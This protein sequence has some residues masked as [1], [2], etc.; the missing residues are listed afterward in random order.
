MDDRYKRFTPHED[1]VDEI[2][3][4]DHVNELQTQIQSNQRELYR[5]DD[6]DFLDRALFIL[7]HHTV[8]N[9]LYIDLIDDITKVDLPASPGIIFNEE[10][11]SFTLEDTDLREALLITKP[12][13]NLNNTN[14]RDVIFMASSNL[15]VGSQITYEISNNGVNFYKIEPNEANV[16]EIPTVG[17]Q[18]YLR[19][20]FYRSPNGETP[21]LKG[22]AIL[23]R[24]AKYVVN[25]AILDE[26]KGECKDCGENLFEGYSHKDLID[27][28]PD[29]HHPQEHKH[30][31]LDGSGII[32]HTVLA[33][34][35]ED[36]H[37]AKNHK[38]GQD[39]VDKVDL[40][41]DVMGTLDLDHL[42][43]LF[44]T[45]EPGDLE[46]IRNPKAEDK[47]VKVIAPDS[48]TY[49]LYD[50][51]NEGRLDT[52]VTVFGDVAT[53]EKMVYGN[54]TNGAGKVEVVM[55]GTE[56]EIKDATDAEVTALMAKVMAPKPVTP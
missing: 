46:L 51:A 28:G 40:A 37:H 30:D 11:R 13:Q 2:I 26:E 14:M 3:S 55:Q 41:T 12:F 35:G 32:S 52:V 20:R 44:V 6:V 25:F 17:S 4:S 39:G 24:D 10:E 27:V 23:F 42:S 34:I 53:I 50:W 18:L 47:L 43:H 19:I 29:D 38:H 5:Q 36:D 9:S 45:G 49:L 16:Y 56:K 33:D 22:Y 8:V 7:E 1:N 48:E 54:Y 31:G 15:P 21:M